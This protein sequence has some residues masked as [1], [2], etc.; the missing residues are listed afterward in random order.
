MA[1][2]IGNITIRY[3]SYSPINTVYLLTAFFF[4]LI[5]FNCVFT[6][7]F[8]WSV[9][10]AWWRI[11]R[12]KRLARIIRVSDAQNAKQRT[13]VLARLERLIK[14]QYST[15]VLYLPILSV[16]TD[17]WRVFL[18]RVQY[19]FFFQQRTCTAWSYEHMQYS[20]S[21]LVWLQPD[22]FFLVSQRWYLLVQVLAYVHSY[23]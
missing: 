8:Y 12:T 18:R 7:Y 1:V 11:N 23:P 19:R 14:K 9:R 17:Y 5:T 21:F 20:T 3:I 15:R 13:N 4:F 10:F 16:S 22:Y 6:A 2:Q